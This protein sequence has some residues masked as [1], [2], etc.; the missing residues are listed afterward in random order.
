M[1]LL[2]AAAI[3]VVI[4]SLRASAQEST[5]D[6]P[7][8]QVLAPG[9]T[10]AT[11]SDRHGL[12]LI[13]V[14][15]QADHHLRVLSVDAQGAVDF[16]G[17][18]TL[19]LPLPEALKNATNYPLQVVFHPTLDLV[20]VWQDLSGATAAQ[21]ATVHATFDHLLIYAIEGRSLTLVA[22]A[23]RGEHFLH[24]QAY[25][26]IAVDPRGRRIFMSGLP[27]DSD[28]QAL[29]YFDLDQHGMPMPVPTPIAG[30]LD[31]YGLNKHEMKLIP[32]RISV[33]NVQNHTT[34]FGLVAPS[35]DVVMFS[36]YNGAALWDTTNRRAALGYFPIYGAPRDNL[37]GAH[38]DLPVIFGAAVGSHQVYQMEHADGYLSML[39]ATISVAGAR[40]QSKP[41]V[42]PGAPN[43]VAIGGA[44]R[45]DLLPLDAEGR[46]VGE[47]KSIAVKCA[48][49]RGLTYSSKLDRLYVAVEALP[50]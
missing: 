10:C 45:I 34:A 17:A 42:M 12:L 5:P 37:I 40:F 35:T 21:Q 29:G 39:P 31:G 18:T 19:K 26:A 4:L 38:P 22:G 36:A 9:A 1:G 3:T 32:H 50:E 28:V 20:Y 6:N 30:T 47:T 24:G 2:V 14:K 46:F 15:G 33:G 7:L 49:V 23:A 27:G 16:D 13:G 25:G 43:R 44:N 41:V 48:A 8:V 11:I